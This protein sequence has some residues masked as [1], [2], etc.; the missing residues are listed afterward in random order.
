MRPA[1]STTTSRPPIW[2]AAVCSTLPCA[3]SAS[4]VVPPPISTL[5]MCFSSSCERL[6]APQ[7]NPG[8]GGGWRPGGRGGGAPPPPVAPPN[9]PA[10]MEGRGLLDVAVRYQRE[11]GRAAADI[12]VKDVLLFV[13]RAL[14][15]ARAVRREHRFHVVAGG[16][17]DELA[18]HLGEQLA[19][20]LRVLAPQRLPGEDHPAGIDLVRMD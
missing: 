6:A 4:L 12:D 11:L 13:V 7:V 3:T 8:P 16:G 14:G 9:P 2:R 15:G 1:S 17:A 20:R 10:N 5:R 18:A 19:D